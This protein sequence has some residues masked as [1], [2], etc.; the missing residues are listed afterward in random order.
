MRVP[1]P[2]GEHGEVTSGAGFGNR[3][4]SR[5]PRF[6]FCQNT[7][8]N[9]QRGAQG[10]ISKSDDFRRGGHKARTTVAALPDAVSPCT[11]E[12]APKIAT[13]AAGGITGPL[14]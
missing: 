11:R 12:A 1:T 8:E 2:G 4:L 9:D 3:L 5:E 14:L 7:R 6:F 10:W 13:T